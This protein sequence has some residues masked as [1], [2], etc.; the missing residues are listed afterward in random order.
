M[1]ATHPDI[2]FLNLDEQERKKV[3]R[4][5]ESF[6]LTSGSTQPLSDECILPALNSLSLVFRHHLTE[7]IGWSDS[8]VLKNHLPVSERIST[9][10]QCTLMIVIAITLLGE[11]AIR[12]I[13]SQALEDINDL[14]DMGE[15]FMHCTREII[16]QEQL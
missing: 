10:W 2:Q 13:L 12:K 8:D 3:R 1:T 9:C 5:L 7:V 15:L 11:T 4:I 6:M 16:R 14:E